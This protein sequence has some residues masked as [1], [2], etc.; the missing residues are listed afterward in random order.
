MEARP[1][2][3][4]PI[5]FQ[6]ITEAGI[7][8]PPPYF[9]LSHS[10]KAARRGPGWRSALG[11]A[12]VLAAGTV[13]AIAPWARWARSLAPAIGAAADHK[14][15]AIAG[16]RP[17]ELPAQRSALPCFVDGRLVGRFNLED[18]AS[19]NG[20]ASGALQANGDAAAPSPAMPA[21]LPALAAPQLATEPPGPA[22]GFEA[23]LAP[24]PPPRI[25]APQKRLY[26]E[27]RVPA[28]RP[29]HGAPWG[30]R[31]A[32]SP[33]ELPRAHTR[34][35][36]LAARA[37]RPESGADAG[38]APIA[39]VPTQ[40]ASALAVRE[41]YSA[42]GKGD[43]ARAARVVVPEKRG[44]GP[45]SAGELTRQ[46]SGLRAPLRVTKIDPINNDTVFVRYQFVTPDEHIC[47]GSATVDTTN[48][49]GETLVRQIRPL[50]GC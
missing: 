19:R 4:G 7:G 11:V 13:L 25:A 29:R 26:A 39:Q 37:S 45:L 36:A 9:T 6:P 30:P 24:L 2:E 38:R 48:Q 31:Y 47:L 49:G 28:L 1:P 34:R 42:L 12:V 20:V 35:L 33:V 16:A 44:E 46:Y 15:G 23:P 50:N 22:P 41:F 5:F 17:T 21:P 40:Q 18:C 32:E 3:P 14:P 10:A 43:G 27:A 8:T